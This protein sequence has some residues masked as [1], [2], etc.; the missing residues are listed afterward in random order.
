[1]G[2]QK[3]G[4]VFAVLFWR[5]FGDRGRRRALEA[6]LG[7]LPKGT[8]GTD[9]ARAVMGEIRKHYRWRGGKLPVFGDAVLRRLTMPV[10]AIVGGRD[11]MLDSHGT[12]RRL[13]A[14]TPQAEVDLLPEAGHLIGDQTGRILGFLPS[15]R[16]NP[17]ETG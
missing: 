6:A 15:G 5:L 3:Y 14:A 10:L 17:S 7:P 8:A 1:M 11:A 9:P 16:K 2:R 12:K 13:E 4:F